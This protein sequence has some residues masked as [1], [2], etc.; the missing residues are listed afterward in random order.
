MKDWGY[1]DNIGYGAGYYVACEGKPKWIAYLLS[2]R[3]DVHF[4][5]G[6]LVCYF[7][8]HVIE[9]DSHAGPDSGSMAGHCTRCGWSFHTTLY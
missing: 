6:R 2:L 1:W 4:Q 8:D 7:R 9:D 3:D 5:L